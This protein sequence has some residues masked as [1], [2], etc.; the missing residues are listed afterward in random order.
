MRIVWASVKCTWSHRLVFQRLSLFAKEWGGDRCLS[1]SGVLFRNFM[2]CFKEC[3]TWIAGIM[4]PVG[5]PCGKGS[6]IRR[7]G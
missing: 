2:E 5:L 3:V 7:N 1:W 4:M 6:R